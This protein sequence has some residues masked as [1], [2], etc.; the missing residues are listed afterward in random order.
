M[1]KLNRMVGVKVFGWLV[2]ESEDGEPATWNT[3][4]VT[5]LDCQYH[6][7]PLSSGPNFSTEIAAAWEVRA[8]MK[9]RGWNLNIDDYGNRV[10]ANFSKDMLY[11][12]RN[13][14]E[15]INECVAICIAALAV[16]GVP[17]SEIQ[18]AMK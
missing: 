3:R 5:L 10:R 18:E 11:D 13:N 8:A 4:R 17:E 12:W 7:T 2:L 9:E 16:C 14:R 6:N 15:H 1:S